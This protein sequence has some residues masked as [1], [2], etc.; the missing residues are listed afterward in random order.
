MKAAEVRAWHAETGENVCGVLHTSPVG[1]DDGTA[2]ERRKEYGANVL[3]LAPPTAAW[4]ILVAQFRSVVVLLLAGAALIAWLT[5]DPLDAWAIGA[6]LFLNA[7]IGFTTEMRARRAIES[8]TTLTPRRATVKRPGHTVGVDVDAGTLVPGDVVIV[9]AGSAVPADA[10]LLSETGLRVNESPLTGESVPVSKTTAALPPATAL[11]DRANMIYTGTTVADGR[12]AAVVVATGMQ[13]EIGRIG[14]LVSAIKEGRTPLE[15]R[16]DALGHRLVWLALGIAIVVG[17]LGWWQGLPWSVVV[18]TSLALAVAAVPEG[19]P[20]VAT[21]ALAVGVRRMARRRALVRRVPAV[22]S[23]GAVTVVCTDKTGTLT[24]GNMVATRLWVGGV[25]HEI[26]GTGYD[27]TGTITPPL[28]AGARLTVEAAVLAGRGDAVQEPDGWTAHGD[29]TD[30]ALLVLGRRVGVD[31]AELSTRWPET[32]EVPFTSDL[33]LMATF[34]RDTTASTAGPMRAAVKGAPQAILD[35]CSLWIDDGG[36]ASPL[37]DEVRATIHAVN[38]TFAS[39]GLRVI[40]AADA[41]SPETTESAL[42]DMTFLGLAGLIDPPADGV[43]ETIA[44]FKQ[45]GIRTVM[46]TGDQAL[47]ARAIGLELGVIT[48]DEEVVTGQTVDDWSDQALAD[49]LSTVGAYSR[50]SPDAKLRIVA[51][52]QARGEIVAVLGDGVNDAAALKQAD[53]GVAMGRRGTDVARDAADVVLQDDWFPTIGAAIEEGRVIYDNIRKFVFY[54]FSCNL[55]EIIVLLVAGVCGAAPLSAIQIL[56]LNLVTDT[57]PALALAMEPADPDVMTR[58]PR[59]PNA[60]LLT[61]RFLRSVATHATL[62]AA[63]T[64]GA[65]VWARSAHPTHAATVAFMTLALAQL[66]HLGTAR[67]HDAVVAPRRVVAN[68]WAL[69]AVALVVGLQIAAVTVAPLQR[70][71]KTESLGV[72]EWA[73]VV[74]A[75]ALPAVLAQLLRLRRSSSES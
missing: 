41:R 50:V 38:A 20:A 66:F 69:G 12:A 28:S 11:A 3:R 75:A 14:G 58:P 68:P 30:V 45:A 46:I 15:L 18:A 40:G 13:T 4:R 44:Q 36:N 2:A 16:L 60:A 34:H 62:L 9:E 37:T 48:A 29:P 25:H 5:S 47:T 67:S 6:V 1:L 39:E 23:L 27:P 7:A 31:R 51:G 54:L 70:V 42:H 35:R 71:L 57:F 24:A 65:Y 43:R 26:T 49:A 33:R 61:R 73:V 32:G 55:A 72:V 19:L 63:V 53:V 59:S 17:A 10:R 74:V 56:W 8:L 21:I 52:L 22:E 64:L